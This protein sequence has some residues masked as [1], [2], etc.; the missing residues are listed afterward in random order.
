MNSR[1][2]RTAYILLLCVTL[3][4]TGGTT[5]QGKGDPDTGK[6]V[7]YRDEYGVP[8]IYAPTVEAGAYAVGYAQAEDRL[9]EL[10]KNM[11]RGTGEMAAA[12]GPDEYDNDLQNRLWQHNDFARKNF[13]R[14]RPEVRR[15][16]AA[17]IQGV[18][19]YLA[20]HQNEVPAWWGNRKLDVYMSLSHSRQ[21]MWSWPAGQ[22][23][24]ELRGAGIAPNFTA[25]MRSSN[26]MAISPS[27]SSAKAPI[28]VIDPH[29]SWWGATRFWEFR[30]HAGEL[31]GSG[32]TIP[33]NPYVGLGHTDHV[34]WA[35]T[36]GGPD[37]ADIYVLTLNPNNSLEYKY[38]NGWK[39]LTHR[40]VKISVKGEDKPREVTF[41]DSHNGPVVARQ[42][43]K[44]FVAKLAYADEVQYGEAFY[45][46]NMAKNVE[47]FRRALDLNQ[48]M[49]QNVMVA[50]TSGNIYYQ[51][52]GRVPI[53]PDGYDFT[54]PVDGSTS[55]TEWLGIHPARDLISIENPAQ[56]YMQNCNIS[57]DVMMVNSPMTPEKKKIYMFNQPAGRTHQRAARMVE[58]LQEDSS[59]TPEEAIAISLDNHCYQYERWTAA[60]KTAD[61]KH[62]A[63]HKNDSDYQAGLREIMSWKGRSDSE[64]R[65]ALKYYYWRQGVKSVLGSSYVALVTKFAD[66]MAALDK[67]KENVDPPTEEELKALVEGLSSAMRVMRE[68]HQRLEVNYGDVFRAGRDDKS[69]P[70]SGGSLQDEGMATPRAI[71]FGPEHPDHTR[72]GGSGQTSTQVVVLSKPVQSWTQP[73]IGQSDRPGSL[74]YRDQA[75]K[76]FSPGKMKPTWYQKRELLKHVHSR[77]ELNSTTN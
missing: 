49:P 67:P 74:F 30:I 69:W 14:I 26:Q 66:Y 22:A 11:L 42:G 15:Y 31:H 37:T 60:L 47:D 73:P 65:G 48:I 28:L 29:L 5:A 58:I 43:N 59:V 19:D 24:G 44:A 18:N 21:F 8:H 41:Y 2:S 54:K 9:E 55:K 33:G 36:T 76:L 38:D 17:Y 16:M 56:G 7:L 61:S 72:W 3:A 20:A 6:V 45:L 71:G 50:D 25:D 57:P 77:V 39:A 23:L 52:T 53:R 46:F 35:M 34:A 51:R 10:L 1:F 64:S 40:N 4:P 27:R 62:G 32:F 12:F 75:E 63:A 70:V 68:K 13:Q